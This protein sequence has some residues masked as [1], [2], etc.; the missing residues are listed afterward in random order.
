L[1]KTGIKYNSILAKTIRCDRI[2]GDATKEG[3]L[4]LTLASWITSVRILLI[5]FIFWQLVDGSIRGIITAVI[6]LFLASMTDML[7][8]WAARARNEITE[9]GKTLDPLADKLVI[10]F[11]LLALVIRLNFPVWLF[12]I[13]LF[14]ET[15]QL[16]TGL[17]LLRKYRQLISANWWGKSATILFFLGFGAFFLEQWAG[18]LII[19]IA[20]ALSIYAFFTYYLAYRE[21]KKDF[22]K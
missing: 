9:L 6:L 1:D 14:K 2:K 16:L 12:L 18:V 8:G 22:E 13:Y 7:D 4:C 5:P 11:T 15:F 21:L 20:V 3:V 17:L 19:G 10:L